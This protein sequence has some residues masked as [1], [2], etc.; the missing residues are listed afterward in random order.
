[1]WNGADT[2]IELMLLRHGATIGNQE[3]RYIGRTDEHLSDLGISQMRQREILL[4]EPQMQ[5]EFMQQDELQQDWLHPDIVFVS[6]MIRCKESAA[7]LWKNQSQIEIEEWRE[8]NFGRYEGLNY[9]DLQKEPFYQK[10]IDSNGALPFP[11]GESRG[12]FIQRCQ[13]GFMQMQTILQKQ[14]IRK[15][16]VAAIVHGGTIMALLSS[17]TQGSYYDYQV[18]NACGYLLNLRNQ[19]DGK[20]EK[21]HLEH[22][23]EIN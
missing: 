6:P 7:I 16:M 23:E 20:L 2:E 15:P 10:W 21:I 18:K 22:L 17:L 14:E 5:S 13:N 19:Q 1:M 12:E 8:M 11:G 9:M 4:R 3:H